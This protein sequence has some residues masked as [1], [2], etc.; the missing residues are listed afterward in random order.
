MT[1][2]ATAIRL[3]MADL[4]AERLLAACTMLALAAVLAPLVILAGLRAGVIQG[5]HEALLEDPRVRE[6][7]TASNRSFDAAL[8]ARLA[9]RPDV[10]FLAPRTRTLAASLLIER[11]DAAGAGTRVELIPTAPGDPLLPEA[12]T[13]TDTIVLTASAAARLRVGAGDA[14]V[15]RLARVLDGRRESVVLALVVQAVA[16]PSAFGR[17]AAFVP[18]PLAVLVEDFQ[19]G[20]IG[21][22]DTVAWLAPPDRADYAGFRLYARRLE[23]LPALDAALQ[24]QGIE[25]VSRAADV[26]G[27]LRVDRNLS[28]LFGLVAGLGGLGFLVSLGAGLWANVERKRVP[29]AQLRFLGL[30]AGSLRLFPVAQ[31]AVLAGLGVGAALAAALAASIVVNRVFAGTLALDRPLCLITPGLAAAAAAVTIGGAVLVAA[32]AGTRAGR[33][34]PW[35]G[36]SA[37]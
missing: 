1:Q 28:L 3:A 5:L 18:L 25:V 36:L 17:D 19:D 14:L 10:A 33:V 9:A 27:L 6:V 24:A 32:A 7:T 12:P 35:E 22:P 16:P 20:R 23:T 15:G 29:L 4:I 26:S 11:P 2:W 13:G 21:P 8:L 37:P 30:R 31:A 34:E